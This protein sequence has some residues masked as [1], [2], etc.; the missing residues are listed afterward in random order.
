[1]SWNL[2]S[3]HYNTALFQSLLN[4]VIDK[5]LLRPL[6][7]WKYLRAATRKNFSKNISESR[8]AMCAALPM[9]ESA[10]LGKALMT[11]YRTKLQPLL[12]RTGRSKLWIISA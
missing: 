7:Y 8:T 6:P 12:C 4:E 10:V 11:L 2:T 9:R 3:T 1:M 5:S